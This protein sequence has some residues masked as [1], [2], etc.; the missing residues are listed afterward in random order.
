MTHI[1]S[2]LPSVG[3]SCGY[4]TLLPNN[5]KLPVLIVATLEKS[6]SK[7]AAILWPGALFRSEGA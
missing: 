3:P 2:P 4:D 6:T 5:E 1:R 7:G